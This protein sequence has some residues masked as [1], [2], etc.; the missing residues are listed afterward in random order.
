MRLGIVGWLGDRIPTVSD[1]L[2]SRRSC[3]VT[4]ASR[5]EVLVSKNLERQRGVYCPWRTA[6]I[7]KLE[8]AFCLHFA[9]AVR[10]NCHCFQRPIARHVEHGAMQGL[11]CKRRSNAN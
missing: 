7:R 9:H 11:F 1:L 8:A 3:L 6:W 4:L 2:F 10:R 5:L